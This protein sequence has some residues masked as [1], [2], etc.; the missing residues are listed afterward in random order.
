M[1]PFTVSNSI[2]ISF[3]TNLKPKENQNEH[4]AAKGRILISPMNKDK[5]QDIEHA[6]E[7]IQTATSY[8]G[9]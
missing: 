4:T 7:N 3:P 6:S 9:N 2:L 5:M 1:Q 8:L